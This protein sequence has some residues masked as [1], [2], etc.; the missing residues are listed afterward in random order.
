MKKVTTILAMV[1]FIV[2]SLTAVACGTTSMSSNIV[3]A[4]SLLSE[5]FNESVTIESI[6]FN[7]CDRLTIVRCRN[8]DILIC[9]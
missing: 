3:E 1:M 9:E 7:D 2:V 6:L 5:S 8:D 4:D